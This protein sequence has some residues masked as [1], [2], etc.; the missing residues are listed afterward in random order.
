MT[1]IGQSAGED[2]GVALGNFGEPFF[3]VR[4]SDRYGLDRIPS[5]FSFRRSST[6]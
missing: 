3:A 4:M 1:S 2:G 5:E 6:I